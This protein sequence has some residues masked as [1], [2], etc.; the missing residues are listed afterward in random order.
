[1]VLE[2]L[3]LWRACLVWIG[4]FAVA[5]SA[6]AQQQ[7]AGGQAGQASMRFAIDEFDIEGNSLLQVQDVETAVLPF[8]GADRSPQDVDDAR[9]ALERV[10]HDRGFKTVAV[11]IPKQSVKEGIV[12]LEVVESKVRLLQIN[13]SHYHSLDRIRSEAGSLAEGQVPDFNAVEKDLLTLNQQP[14][15]RVTP[16]LKAGPT[17]DTVDVDLIVTDEAPWHGS[18][19]LN[20]RQSEGTEPLRASASLS[21]DNLWQRGHV[22]GLSWLV[23]PEDP[24]QSEVWFGSY[25]AR[26]GRSP[27]TLLFTAIKSDSDVATVGG[28]QVIGNGD[29]YGAHAFLALGGDTTFYHSLSLA[30][31]YK[32]ST[33]K[34]RLGTDAYDTP[35][36]YTPLTLDYTAQFTGST[37]VSTGFDSSVTIV[38][39]LTGSDSAKLD[40]NRAYARTGFFYLRSGL[41]LG[42]QLPHD[43]GLR[44][45]LNGQWTDQPLITN[46]QFTAGGADTVRGYYEA[47]ALGDY[48]GMFSL[49]LQSA[50]VGSAFGSASADKP[51]V[52]QM[53]GHVFVDGAALRIYDALPEQ[54]HGEDL[55]SVGVGVEFKALGFLDGDL[56][57]GMAATDGP[58]TASGESRVLFRVSGKF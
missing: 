45:R 10:Y 24:S 17:P 3:W 36:R 32:R 33:I 58:A 37:R 6:A 57:W 40:A 35:I 1:M 14:G 56:D 27:W 50:D 8:M 34:T 20:N 5:S 41:D 2:A 39:S 26:V 16:A 46:E 51:W 52:E 28:T 4:A 55:L 23:A 19:E 29:F 53:R 15:R 12:R 21:Y 25:M 44:I 9:A 54:S 7:G 22:L 18:L 13:G 38:P 47:E 31:D 49:Q 42:V 11:R 30:A 43:M 48:G